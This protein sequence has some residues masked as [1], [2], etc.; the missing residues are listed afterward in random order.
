MTKTE[1]NTPELRSDLT[2][3]LVQRL[4][5]R[6][7][8]DLIREELRHLIWEGECEALKK[9]NLSEQHLQQLGYVISNNLKASEVTLG[10][11][12]KWNSEEN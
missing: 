8:S 11:D 12:L 1:L 5:N 3:A 7:S 4:N 2:E 6:Y 10:L 9:L